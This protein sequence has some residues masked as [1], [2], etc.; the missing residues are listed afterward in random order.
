MR[1]ERDVSQPIR[2]AQIMGCMNGGGVEQTVMNYY[3]YIDYNKIQFDFIVSRDS[4]IVP[5]EEIT[6]RGG[7]I[8]DIAPYWQQIKYQ[9]ELQKILKCEGWKIV[10]SHINAMSVFPL[11]AAYKVG[12]PVRIAHSHS[13][14]GK[15]EFVKNFIKA[16]LR[17][18]ANRYPTVRMACSENAGKWLFGR[19]SCAFLPS[20]IE[21][22][23]YLYGSEKR[24]TIRKAWGISD[25]MVVIGHT[26][27][28]APAKNQIFLIRVLE[29]CK[30]NGYR[31]KLVL[32]GD[33]DDRCMLEKETIRR[34]LQDDVIMPG[35]MDTAA[36]YS[37]FD[38][39]AFPSL[40]EGFGMSAVEAQVSGLPC[41]LSEHV[42]AQTNINNRCTVLPI[43]NPVVWAKSI[44]EIELNK[45]RFI[46]RTDFASLD[47]VNTA[48]KLTDFYLKQYTY[49]E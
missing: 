36:V 35:Y 18:Q 40:Y 8:F 24:S 19:S 49:V 37:G 11:Y 17:T 34:N 42:P 10:H 4:R 28:F 32:I 26:G 1:T 47:V 39:F 29:E 31:A 25:D 30:K 22:Q 46:N 21:V 44:M 5:R 45:N 2:V 23:K 43:D 38:I 6:D 20:A 33:G 41:I 16:L 15:G 13:T 9:R 48:E 12:V 3:R 27:R 14:W 7:R